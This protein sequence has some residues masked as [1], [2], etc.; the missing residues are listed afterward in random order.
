MNAGARDL[1]W[2]P[3]RAAITWINMIT[4]EESVDASRLHL[5]HKTDSKAAEAEGCRSWIVL[6]MKALCFNI[7]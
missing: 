4:M 7:I 1:T 5:I 2:L 6:F 3:G